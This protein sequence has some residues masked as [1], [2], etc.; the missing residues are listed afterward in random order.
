MKKIVI[1]FL[2]LILIIIVICSN[3][4]EIK[5]F[6]HSKHN[7]IMLKNEIINLNKFSRPRILFI[8]GVH[9]NEPAGCSALNQF[10]QNILKKK[11][12]ISN[13]TIINIPCVNICGIK[14]N[15]R[16]IPYLKEIDIN[17]Y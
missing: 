4:N 11:L 5:I 12:V 9:G 10:S 13:G 6:I 16:Y 1:F 8:G 3:C 17:D 14:A 2:F 15:N 7:N